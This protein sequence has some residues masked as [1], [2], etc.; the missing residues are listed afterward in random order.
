MTLGDCERLFF[1]CEQAALDGNCEDIVKS[2]HKLKGMLSTFEDDGVV[3]NIQ[4][5]ITAGR[6]C[7][8]DMA[9]DVYDQNRERVAE[10][11]SAIRHLAS[12]SG[13]ATS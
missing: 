12:A 1:E 9:R 6:Q 3:L 5:I 10:L 13:T 8:P 2:W 4:D 7:Q 11:V